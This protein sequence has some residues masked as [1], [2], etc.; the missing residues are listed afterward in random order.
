MRDLLV[1]HRDIKNEECQQMGVLFVGQL[2]TKAVK[3]PG[4]ENG[5]FKFYK[6]K[7]GFSDD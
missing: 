5:D 2:L 6:Y 3:V 4:V 1:L 7:K